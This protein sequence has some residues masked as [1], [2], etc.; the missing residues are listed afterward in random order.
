ML[1]YDLMYSQWTSKSIKM[2]KKVTPE[3][4]NHILSTQFFKHDTIYHLLKQN[5]LPCPCSGAWHYWGLFILLWI[6]NTYLL[7]YMS[8]KYTVL[9]S[10]RALASGFS[11]QWCQRSSCLPLAI[12]DTVLLS[13]CQQCW[14]TA[15]ALLLPPHPLCAEM[16][17]YFT[18]SHWNQRGGRCLAI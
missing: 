16:L 14:V 1:E 13:V 17:F 7:L 11:C 4:P 9:M 15:L 18:G 3:L 8:F 2:T 12:T 6:V 10:V 5:V